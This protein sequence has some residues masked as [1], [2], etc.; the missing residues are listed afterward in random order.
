MATRIE[1]HGRKYIGSQLYFFERVGSSDLVE[2]T[3]MLGRILLVNI[4]RGTAK[5]EINGK[6]FHLTKSN[7]LFLPPH[8]SIQILESSSDLEAVIVGFMMALQEVIL[9]KLGHAFFVF[10]F[11]KLVWKLSEEGKRIMDAFCVLYEG[12]CK[13]PTDVYSADIA[14]SMFNIFLLSFYQ[15]VKALFEKDD[16]M[17]TLN[18]KS[19][20][21]RFVFLL[22]ENFKQE[23]SVAFYADKLCISSKYLTQIIKS[24][25]GTTPKVAIDHALGVEALF[26][27]G[28]TSLNVQEISLQLGF[29]D[30]SY[31]GRFFKRLFGMSPL[32][33]RMNPDLKLLEKIRE[34]TRS[35][36]ELE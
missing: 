19:L 23:H 6:I 27:L 4:T 32:H 9:Q 34:E 28:N 21:A 31:F 25:T 24:N 33:Y 10:V 11:K 36:E 18:S 8:S 14:N 22:H 20:A 12:H 17:T 30:Q 15:N 35:F 16:A 26:L 7:F 29:P 13:S 5:V 3:Y 1:D 2:K